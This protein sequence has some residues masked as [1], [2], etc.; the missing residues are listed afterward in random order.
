MASRI[1]ERRPPLGPSSSLQLPEQ[2]TP[3][4]LSR[5]P[6]ML[7]SRDWTHGQLG[8]GAGLKLV[9]SGR[10]IPWGWSFNKGVREKDG[11]QRT[12]SGIKYTALSTETHVVTPAHRKR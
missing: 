12:C 5:L 7:Q 1:G 9:G 3:W 2:S 6:V 8:G 4:L 11:T 10:E